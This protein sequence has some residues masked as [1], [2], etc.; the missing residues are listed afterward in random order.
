[1]EFL[2]NN[3]SAAGPVN[4]VGVDDTGSAFINAARCTKLTER[5]AAAAALADPA[6][7]LTGVVRHEGL[8]CVGGGIDGC[9][10]HRC[11]PS[12][13]KTMTWRPTMSPRA[14]ACRFSLMSSSLT[15]VTLCLIRPAS[16]RES[17]S[18]RSRSL[19]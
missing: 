4:D 2:R 16:A 11:R 18:T 17:T 14:R 3:R 1:M 12:Q 13:L 7:D 6:L 19:P 5:S 15:L 8:H 9:H 10:R